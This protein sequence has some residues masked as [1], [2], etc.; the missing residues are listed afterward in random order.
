MASIL[1]SDGWV[2]QMVPRIFRLTDNNGSYG[3]PT[4]NG[5]A[6]GLL[7]ASNGYVNSAIGVLYLMKGTIPASA[8]SVSTVSARSSDVLVPF[9][10]GVDAPGDF[11]TSQV[12]VNP[13]VI[14]TQYKSA[15]GSGVAT[16]FW[17]AV[18][19]TAANG[20]ADMNAPIYHQVIG[21]V[22]ATGSGSDLEIPNTSIVAGTSYRVMNFRIQFP[23]S[24][25]Y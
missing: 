19:G 20:F 10:S 22:G 11:I 17:I 14:S 7:Q 3:E 21:T 25:T 1:L 13:A 18:S 5:A 6:V 23:T 2:S 4:T 9:S 8:T 15:T 12:N 16:W 24:W